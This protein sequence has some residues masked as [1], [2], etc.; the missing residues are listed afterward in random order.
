[1]AFIVFAFTTRTLNCIGAKRREN[2]A[3]ALLALWP[4]PAE[5]PIMVVLPESQGSLWS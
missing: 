5:D 4:P 2:H 1:M 3:P